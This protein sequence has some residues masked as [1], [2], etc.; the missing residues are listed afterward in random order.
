[1]LIMASLVCFTSCSKDDDEEPMPNITKEQI[2]G[3]WYKITNTTGEY[4]S[5]SNEVIWTFNQNN[6]ATE[7]VLMKMNNSSYY[8]KTL[9][10][11]YKLNT[12]GYIK[13]TTEKNEVLNYEISVN[14]NQMRLGNE[15]DGYFNLTKK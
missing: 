2:L 5:M 7:R 12:E 14:G 4:V 11:T 1:M 15:A 3:S 13:L 6:T 8:D 9:S 10:F